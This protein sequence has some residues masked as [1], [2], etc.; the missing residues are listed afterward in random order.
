MLRPAL[1][2][3]SFDDD[4][5]VDEEQPAAA[6]NASV[7]SEGSCLIEGGLK[8]DYGLVAGAGGW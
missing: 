2:V 4:I 6:S 7:V 1:G 8:G 3:T 5:E